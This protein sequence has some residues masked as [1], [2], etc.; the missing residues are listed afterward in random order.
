MKHYKDPDTN[1]IYAYELDGSQDE[2]IKPNLVAITNDEA[3]A[4]LD[5][6]KAEQIAVVPMVDPVTK[7]QEFLLA[8]PDVANLINQ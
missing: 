6:K 2:W 8:N 7:L 5:Q 1:E 3:K 4:I